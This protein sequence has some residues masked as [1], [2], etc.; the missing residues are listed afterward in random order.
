M[1][2][3]PVSSSTIAAVGHEA[4]QLHVRF[5]DRKKKDGTTISGALYEYDA[6]P[7]SVH[8]TLL[9]A[10]RDPKLSVGKAFDRF[11]KTAGYTY[12]RIA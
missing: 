4:N 11:V 5:V 9:A 7:A 1:K 2:M 3:V 10:D 6:V 12:R 8:K